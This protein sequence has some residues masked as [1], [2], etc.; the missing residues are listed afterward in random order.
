MTKETQKMP[1]PKRRT[2]QRNAEMGKKTACND[3]RKQRKK[4]KKNSTDVSKMQPQQQNFNSDE[5]NAF[6]S[7]ALTRSI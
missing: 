1:K 4:K 7:A 5:K 6:G 2:W 3:E